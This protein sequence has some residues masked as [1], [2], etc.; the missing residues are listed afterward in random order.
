MISERIPSDAD[1]RGSK[2]SPLGFT[3]ATWRMLTKVG[4][5]SGLSR[6][7]QANP[8]APADRV[9]LE[10]IAQADV[11]GEIGSHLPI[12]LDVWEE[13]DGA[14]IARAV[15]CGGRICLALELNWSC[16]EK[17]RQGFRRRRFR[18]RDRRRYCLESWLRTRRK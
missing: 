2:L 13:F 3:L 4:D 15:E 14:R 12:V 17:S 18:L 10:V 8:G 11:H 5:V 6:L 7:V 16:R 1:S 9:G